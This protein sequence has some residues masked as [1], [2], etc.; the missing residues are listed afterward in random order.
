VTVS[1][2]LDGHRA[3]ISVQDNG[4]GIEPQNIPLLFE[5]FAQVS[6]NGHGKTGGS[7]LGLAISKKIVKAHGGDIWVESA[8]GRGATFSFTLPLMEVG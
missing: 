3:R 8:Y 6:H 7:G 1:S 5:S 2:E 4:C